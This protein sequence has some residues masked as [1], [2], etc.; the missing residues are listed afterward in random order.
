MAKNKFAAVDPFIGWFTVHLDYVSIGG[1]KL[2][3]Q[4]SVYNTG[5]GVIVDSGT[6]D[7]YLPRKMAGQFKKAWK[8]GGLR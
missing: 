1:T 7:T 5:K 6:T 8:V 2:E 3:V 4:D